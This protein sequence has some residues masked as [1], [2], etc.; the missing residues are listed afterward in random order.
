MFEWLIKS[1]MVCYGIFWSGQYSAGS[2]AWDKGG[3]G[4]WAAVIQTLREE[5]DAVSK[6]FFSA[7]RASVRSENKG[8][9]R[10]QALPLD[11]PLQ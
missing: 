5:G 9:G 11:P 3:G 10:P 8:D 7:R 2:R 4:E 6:K 1:I